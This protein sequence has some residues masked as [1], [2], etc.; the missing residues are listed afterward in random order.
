MKKLSTPKPSKMSLTRETLR[1]LQLTEVRGA[2]MGIS[3]GT[4]T[5]CKDTFNPSCCGCYTSCV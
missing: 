1:S 5:A 2:M 3:V 4:C